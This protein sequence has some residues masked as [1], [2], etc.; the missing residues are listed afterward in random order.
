M[1]ERNFVFAVEP[2]GRLYRSLL[3]CGLRFCAKVSLVVRADLGLTPEAERL[4]SELCKQ[5][6]HVRQGREWPGTILFDETAQVYEIRYGV[7]VANLLAVAADGIF[8]WQ[9]PSRPEDLCL[10]RADGSAWLTSIVHEHDAFL[11]LRDEE[12]TVVKQ[13]DPELHAALLLE[14]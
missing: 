6:C 3:D 10:L 7:D 1:S 9:Q 8:D 2:S 11:T 13:K 14:T 4:L 12:V 5:D